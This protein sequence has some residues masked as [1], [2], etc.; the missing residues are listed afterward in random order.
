MVLAARLF[1]HLYPRFFPV[2][3][4]AKA[5]VAREAAL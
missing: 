4:T 5:H 2:P 1:R 3:D